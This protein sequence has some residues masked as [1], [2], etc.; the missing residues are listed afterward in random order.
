VCGV[1]QPSLGCTS[2]GRKAV[3][4]GRIVREDRGEVARDSA[5]DTADQE[6]ERAGHTHAHDHDAPSGLWLSGTEVQGESHLPN[7]AGHVLRGWVWLWR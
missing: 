1:R 7:Q 4:D 5:H 6:E 2:S 3:A